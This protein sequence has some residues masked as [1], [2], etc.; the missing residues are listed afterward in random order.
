MLGKCAE[1]LALRKAFP[2][3]M[4]GLYTDEE[5]DQAD[6][7]QVS[8]GSTFGE[9]NDTKGRVFIDEVK[10][11]SKEESEKLMDECNSFKYPA[12]SKAG[13]LMNKGLSEVKET[14]EPEPPVPTEVPV[15]DNNKSEMTNKYTGRCYVCGEWVYE[16]KGV[17]EKDDDGKWVTR[18]KECQPK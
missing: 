2:N 10:P 18:H 9:E 17:L 4:S 14:K 6:N 16:K 12:K 1:A 7:N 13:E 15:A 8:N 3:D 5:M 11:V